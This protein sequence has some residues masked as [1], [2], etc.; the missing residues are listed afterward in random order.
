MFS[1]KK[2]ST[3]YHSLVNVIFNEIKKSHLRLIKIHVLKFEYQHNIV[4]CTGKYNSRYILYMYLI[5][6]QQH[7][8]GT[9]TW[10][11]PCWTVALV[12]VCL[13]NPPG[14]VWPCASWRGG[15]Q[16]VAG[17]SGFHLGL[18]PELGRHTDPTKT[19]IQIIRLW[20]F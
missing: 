5:S 6:T 2:N 16:S 11:P 9:N 19:Q 7:S 13:R 12:A 3:I 14:T 20:K 15:Y 10:V 4:H 18:L 1:K 8:K 17:A